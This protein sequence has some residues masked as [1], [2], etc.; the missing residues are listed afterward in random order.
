MPQI[1]VNH[2]FEGRFSSIL[3]A[4]GDP[5]NRLGYFDQAGE[6][7]GGGYEDQVAGSSLDGGFQ[8][9]QLLRKVAGRGSP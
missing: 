5:Q 3:Y 6:I 8:V 7:N 1:I 2:L 4:V 9:F